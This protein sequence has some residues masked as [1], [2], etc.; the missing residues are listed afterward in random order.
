MRKLVEI[1]DS[2]DPMFGRK[3][4]L[5]E[6]EVKRMLKAGTCKEIEIKNPLPFQSIPD[7]I[8][9]PIF[10]IEFRTEFDLL[11]D[12]RRNRPKAPKGKKYRRDWYDSMTGDELSL[13]FFWDEVPRILQKTS[14]LS[15][16]KRMVISHV[17]DTAIRK[18]T[19]TYIS[20]IEEKEKKTKKKSKE[21]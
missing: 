8:N 18:T 11:M 1:T 14:D 12:R 4:L 7:I 10:E 3:M 2:T 13:D 9:D 19:M 20:L 6:K 16:N 17:T 21:G 15:S 5:E